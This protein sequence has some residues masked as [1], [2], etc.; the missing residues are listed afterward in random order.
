MWVLGPKLRSSAKASRTLNCHTISLVLICLS[1]WLSIYHLS[2]YLWTGS[3][4]MLTVLVRVPI[5]V[6]RDHDHSNSYRGQHSLGAGVQFRSLVHYHQG[7]K[8]W[9]WKRSWELYIW[10]SRHQEETISHYPGLS[11][12]DLKA[13][14]QW[15][16]SLNKVTPTPW[17]PYL[18]IVLCQFLSNHHTLTLTSNLPG[19]AFQCWYSM[20]IGLTFF[21]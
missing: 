10:I 1:V 14:P 9:H 16:T 6:K 17:R 11:I 18:L 19:S 3:W 5:V 8:T 12:W 4:P 7:R 21:K 20:P 13:Y 2:I 15:H